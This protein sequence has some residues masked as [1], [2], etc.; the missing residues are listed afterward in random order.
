M[1][2]HAGA[3][4]G[5]VKN[6]PPPTGRELE[7]YQQELQRF[8]SRLT[9]GG[10]QPTQERGTYWYSY[11]FRRLTTTSTTSTYKACATELEMQLVMTTV[12]KGPTAALIML[13]SY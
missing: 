8:I 5:W 9:S 6:S 4:S 1:D 12:K 3:G 10:W 11:R 13:D 7:G 2:G